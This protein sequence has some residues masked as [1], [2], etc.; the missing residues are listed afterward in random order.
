MDSLP[1]RISL[2]HTE[3]ERLTRYLGTLSSDAWHHPSACTGWE[4]GDVVAHLTRGAEAYI[5]WI[6]RGLQGETAPPRG[7]PAAGTGEDAASA[8][9]RAQ[10]ARDVRARLGDHL[11]TTFQARTAQFNALVADMPSQ[12]WAVRCYHP[13]RLRPVRDFV[14]LRITELALHGWDIR[15]RLES[16]ASLSAESLSVCLD[17]LPDMLAWAFHPG[18]ALPTPVHC[19]LVGRDQAP[20]RY[21][22]V[23]TGTQAW[24]VSPGTARTLV[25]C[26]CDTETFVLL[27]SGRLPMPAAR[28]AGRVR[29]EGDPQLMTALTHWF[30]GN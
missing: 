10:R 7:V 29:L 27:M 19:G 25:S 4:V 20:H 1:S 24:L 9:R 21:E 2:V 28:A 15:S 16:D 5:A 22:L 8:M 26:L 13:T 17:L 12:H 30:Q 6:T 18:P 11:F 3:S 23:T 14:D